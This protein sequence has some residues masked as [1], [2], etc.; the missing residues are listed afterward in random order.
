MAIILDGDNG[1]TL[2]KV[3]IGLAATRPLAVASTSS[4]SGGNASIYMEGS[5]NTERFEIRSS[6]QPTFQGKTSGGTVASPTATPIDTPLFALGGSG[7]TGTDWVTVNSSLIRMMASENWTP[8]AYGSKIGFYT[9]PIG[10]TAFTE[11]MVIEDVRI[12]TIGSVFN[13]RAA[14]HTGAFDLTVGNNF[15]CAPTGPITLTFSNFISGQS[16]LI[17]LPNPSGYA[18]SKTSS[19]A[20]DANCLATL[21]APGN[22]VLAYFSGSTGVQV[23]YSQNVT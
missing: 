14:A 1:G 17:Y 8:T 21:S 5:N 10:T 11:K 3:G 13:P 2:P 4:L 9:T 7:H 15:S 23:T 6:F 12:K 20:C 22:Y 16:G 19:M 18:I